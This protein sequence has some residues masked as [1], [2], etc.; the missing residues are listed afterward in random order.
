MDDDK[1]K[2]EKQSLDDPLDRGDPKVIDDE[3]VVGE[4]GGEDYDEDDSDQSYTS[5]E[6]DSDDSDTE[7]EAEVI[8]HLV[9]E[10][11]EAMEMNKSL[12]H[13]IVN[14]NSKEAQGTESKKPQIPLP[15]ADQSQHEFV[16]AILA[17]RTE[18]ELV[19]SIVASRN[20][21]TK[22]TEN[23]DKYIEHAG[24]DCAPSGNTGYST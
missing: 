10:M 21:G 6:D 17:S 20:Q 8:Q 19:A 5:D 14:L 24:T 4:D 16:A 23:R 3:E 12:R 1:I 11:K 7:E 22:T 2:Y 18:Q 9:D 13:E 15:G